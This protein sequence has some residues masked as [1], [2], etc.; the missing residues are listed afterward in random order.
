MTKQNE[1]KSRRDFLR[2]WIGGSLAALPCGAIA[3]AGFSQDAH[4]RRKGR[5]LGRL[6][7]RYPYVTGG[8][9]VAALAWKFLARK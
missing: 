3:L 5:G 8:V 6:V 1:A 4:A 7:T 9:I 2:S